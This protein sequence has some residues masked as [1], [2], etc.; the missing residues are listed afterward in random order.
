MPLAVYL[1]AVVSMSAARAA[2]VLMVKC[3]FIRSHPLSA[4]RATIILPQ[5][6]CIYTLLIKEL[7]ERG[8]AA[9]FAPISVDF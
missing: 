7:S 5:H 4:D 3:P 6:H 1:Y 9:N 2:P 8:L